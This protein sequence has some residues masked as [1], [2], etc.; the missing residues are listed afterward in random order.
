MGAQ[1]ESRQKARSGRESAR[2]FGISRSR[3]GWLMVR[4]DG[5]PSYPEMVETLREMVERYGDLV[6]R[7]ENLSG[8]QW[9]LR[10]EQKGSHISEPQIQAVRTLMERT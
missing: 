3:W 10:I 5:G 2:E 4:F 8:S 9:I 1:Q 7:G 6:K